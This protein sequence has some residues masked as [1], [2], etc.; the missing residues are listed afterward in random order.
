MQKYITI[1]MSPMF[2]EL[3][4]MNA[5]CLRLRSKARLVLT[6][7]DFGSYLVN[8]PTVKPP[9]GTIRS[10]TEVSRFNYMDIELDILGREADIY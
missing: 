8:R 6:I 7:G 5:K 4:W 3:D 10:A 2:L 9:I 1:H